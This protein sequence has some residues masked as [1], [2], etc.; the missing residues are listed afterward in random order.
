[1]TRKTTHNPKGAELLSDQDLDRIH[2]GLV[3]D[4][5]GALRTGKVVGG[6]E[7]EPLTDVSKTGSVV[8]DDVVI[9]WKSR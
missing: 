1:V 4:D 9:N 8:A 2:G 6:Q 7:G 3:G 5:V